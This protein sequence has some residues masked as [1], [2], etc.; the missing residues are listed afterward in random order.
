M[1]Y[2]QRLADALR[3][4]ERLKAE[5]DAWQKLAVARAGLLACYRTGNH[6]GAEKHLTTIDA[7]ESALRRLS[8]SEEGK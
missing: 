5:Q 4:I 8:Q 2:D 1:S 6:R 7:A 3:E